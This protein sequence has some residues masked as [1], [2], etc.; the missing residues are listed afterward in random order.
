MWEIRI[1]LEM[2]ELGGIVGEGGCLSC[3]ET[4]LYSGLLLSLYTSHR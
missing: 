1:A 2:P 4:F 3:G